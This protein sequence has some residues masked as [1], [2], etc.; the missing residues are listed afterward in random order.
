MAILFPKEVRTSIRYKKARYQFW[1]NVEGQGKKCEN[2]SY[3]VG[4]GLSLLLR[5]DGGSFS[6]S[7]RFFASSLKF[8]DSLCL[9]S[10]RVCTAA[11]SSASSGQCCKNWMGQRVPR[12]ICGAECMRILRWPIW[13]ELEGVARVRSA[14]KKPGQWTSDVSHLE[15]AEFATIDIVVT[16]MMMYAKCQVA[17]NNEVI[18]NADTQKNLSKK[19]HDCN[20][21]SVVL[22]KLPGQFLVRCSAFF[23]LVSLTLI[24]L[25][26]LLSSPSKVAFHRLSKKESNKF[27]FLTSKDLELLRKFEWFI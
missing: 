13:S 14:L 15:S 22:S 1:E 16:T 4:F 21:L 17:L 23:G 2:C 7:V 5:N 11:T 3:A 8:S 24:G 25:Q 20:V 19:L 27:F 9:G 10:L 6:S 26:G 12:V 18:D